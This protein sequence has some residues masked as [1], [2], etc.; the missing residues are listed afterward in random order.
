MFP[1]AVVYLC[2]PLY[3]WLFSFLNLW[4]VSLAAVVL[5]VLSCCLWQTHRQHK[6]ALPQPLWC[7]WPLLLI[8]A[9]L[10]LAG[11]WSPFN[12]WDWQ[13]HFALFNLLIDHDWPPHIT[14]LE[15]E[16]FLR[17]GIGWY[18]V[19]ALLTKLSSFAVLTPRDVCVD[20]VRRMSGTVVSL[21]ATYASGGTCCWPR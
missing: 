20:V 10:V 12:Y 15:E 16:Y 18:L 14:L 13:K 8:V 2:V 21:C 3:I 7:Y 4:W 19:P 6:T 1:I 11:I 5:A 17:Y 9:V